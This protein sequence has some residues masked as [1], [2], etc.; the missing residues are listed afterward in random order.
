MPVD[1]SHNLGPP[2]AARA[3]PAILPAILL[4]ILLGAC[5]RAPDKP[6]VPK[7]DLAAAAALSVVGFPAARLVPGMEPGAAEKIRAASSCPP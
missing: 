6:P 2:P 1:L 7:V 3:L 5:E 4:A